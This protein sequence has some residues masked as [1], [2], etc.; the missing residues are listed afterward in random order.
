[1]EQILSVVWTNRGLSNYF[2]FLVVPF[3]HFYLSHLF[4]FFIKT[5]L[6]FSFEIYLNHQFRFLAYLLLRQLLKEYMQDIIIMML[7]LLSLVILRIEN[8]Q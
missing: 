2:T 8:L 5:G 3:R 7:Q 4:Y 1:M 6:Q